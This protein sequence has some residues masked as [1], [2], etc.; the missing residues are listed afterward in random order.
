[1]SGKQEKWGVWIYGQMQLYSLYLLNKIR[2]LPLHNRRS[3]I[4]AYKSVCIGNIL[5]K[6]DLKWCI[7]QWTAE[8]LIATPWQQLHPR[9]SVR[10]EPLTGKC[11][12]TAAFKIK[13][14]GPGEHVARQHLSP[15]FRSFSAIFS[16][17]AYFICGY[18]GAYI[19]CIC[20]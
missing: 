10:H 5:E 20:M 11:L 8:V 19:I 12:Q 7:L 13:V 15:T 6:K 3:L 17:I 16:N 1:M 9:I 14:H 18:I 2:R 4:L